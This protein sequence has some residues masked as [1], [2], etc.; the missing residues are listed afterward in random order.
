[1]VTNTALKSWRL[2]IPVALL[3]PLFGCGA[4]DSVRFVQA[5]NDSNIKQVASVYQLYASRHGY[6]GPKSKEELLDF[7][8]SDDRIARNLELMEIDLANVEDCF[9]S[10]NDSEEFHVRWGV[11]IN[12]DLERSREPLVF[13]RTGKDNVRLVMLSNRKILEVTD[14]AKYQALLKGKVSSTDAKTD[15]QIEE[16]ASVSE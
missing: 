14:D 15:L 5:S 13:E 4:S 2:L 8:I 3:V 12:P 9:V 11:F 7:L 10:E 1:M 16:E 6:L